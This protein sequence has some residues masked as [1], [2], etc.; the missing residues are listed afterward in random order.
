MPA[1]LG[2]GRGRGKGESRVTIGRIIE[3]QDCVAEGAAWLAARE[4][5]FAR[6]LEATGPWPLR[7]QPDGFA[8]LMEAIIGQQALLLLASTVQ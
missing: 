3:G 2:E 5:A 1:A 6:A 8:A 4:P 7:R